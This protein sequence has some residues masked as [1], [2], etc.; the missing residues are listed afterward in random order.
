MAAID[1]ARVSERRPPA[2]RL[3]AAQVAYQLKVLVRSPLAAFMTLVIPLMVLLAVNL[4]FLGTRLSTRGDIRFVQFFTPAMVAFAVINAC[5][6]NVISSTAIARDEGVLKRIRSTPLPSWIYM[7]GRLGCAALVAL[8][9]AIVVLAVGAGVYGFEMIWSA[10]PAVLVTLAMGMFCFCALG[11][12]VTVLV[13]KADSALAIAWGTILPLC[14]ISDVFQPIDKAPHWLR[15]VASVF[16]LRPFADDLESAFNPV[17]GSRAL[18]P[19]HLVLMAAWGVAAAS[20]ALLAFRW[21]PDA[22][23]P[24]PR[25]RP[26]RSPAFAPER[27]RG[28]LNA[29]G[30]R[31]A[32]PP[33]E[34]PAAVPTEAAPSAARPTGRRPV[35]PAPTEWIE[36]PAPAEDSSVPPETCDLD[37]AAPLHS[38][39]PP[40]V[41][42]SGLRAQ[43]LPQML[44]QDVQHA[45]RLAARDVAAQ[46]PVGGR[47]R[48]RRLGF[49]RQVRLV[50]DPPKEAIDVA[51]TLGRATWIPALVE[52]PANE[53]RQLCGKLRGLVHRQVITQGVQKRAQYLIGLMAVLGSQLRRQI[54]QPDV[55][56]LDAPVNHVHANRGH[57]GR[58]S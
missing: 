50:G 52:H 1:G 51:R 41:R 28:L 58:P 29:R 40:P 13:P 31:G 33:G 45:L 7:S 35:E 6:M 46:H 23:H 49:A 22:G 27:V 53:D 10:I 42:A 43:Q 11:L 38:S 9:S 47:G 30:E 56:F 55:R 4:L 12:A 17:T 3:L 2:L 16:P 57:W 54:G 39:P 24:A 32:R 18:H 34:L 44:G 25:A 8:V 36:G 19:G 48:E 37:A 21:E 15:T 14:F 20:F 26:R 5:Y